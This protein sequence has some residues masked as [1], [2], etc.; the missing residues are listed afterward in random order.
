M[1]IVK[2]V[3]ALIKKDDCFLIVRRATG[4][5]N[6][7]GKWEFPGGKVEVNEN[8]IFALKREKKNNLI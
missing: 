1:K 7:L 8:E 6:V 2:I 4:N 5:E 3:A